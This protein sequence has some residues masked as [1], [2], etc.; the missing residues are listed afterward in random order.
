MSANPL[1]V[2]ITIDTTQRVSGLLQTPAQAHACYVMAHGAGAGMAHPLMAAIAQ[3][4]GERR[5]ATKFGDGRAKG[6]P[7]ALDLAS[8]PASQELPRSCATLPELDITAHKITIEGV[9]GRLW[10][11]F[12]LP[13]Y[14][15]SDIEKGIDRVSQYEFQYVMR[16]DPSD[17]RMELTAVGIPPVVEQPGWQLYVILEGTDRHCS[18]LRVQ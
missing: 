16:G 4:L 15:L 11:R 8:F 5:I 2:S 9:E 3:G 6:S 13:S 7:R 12:E 18:L 17:P 1:P 14:V 10:A